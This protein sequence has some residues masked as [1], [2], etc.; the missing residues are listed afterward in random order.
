[1]ANQKMVFK[2]PKPTGK[3]N[4]PIIR[5]TPSCSSRM[6]EKI[7]ETGLTPSQIIEQ[8]FDFIGDN[9]EVR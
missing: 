4:S 9:Y 6:N 5:L 1:M 7:E 2:T 8:M 3:G